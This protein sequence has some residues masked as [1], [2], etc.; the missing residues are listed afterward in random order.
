MPKIVLVTGLIGSGKSAVCRI[1]QRKGYPVY[2]S[3][4]RTKALYRR[5]DVAA[6]LESEIGLDADHLKG[7]FGTP[8][9]LH[10]LEEIIHPEVLKDFRA[11]AAETDSPVVFFESA[12][13]MSLPLFRDIFD[14][15]IL[16][17]AP[18]EKRWE[19][20]QKASQRDAFQSEPEHYD[21]LIE[22]DGPIEALEDKTDLIISQ[23]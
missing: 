13:A 23:L 18:K 7:I 2:D 9:R 19:R 21:F 15:V 17:R 8:D 4:S 5:P 16:V 11:F 6:R 1:L 22:N 12:I 14:S 3:D 10:R 20:N